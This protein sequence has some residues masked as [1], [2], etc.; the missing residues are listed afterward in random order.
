MIQSRYRLRKTWRGPQGEPPTGADRLSGALAVNAGRRPLQIYLPIADMP[1]NIFLVLGMGLAVGYISGMFGIGGGFLMTP[2]LIFIGVS[3]AVAVASVASHIAASSFSGAINYWN[4][5]ALDL[6]LA[7]ML[8]SA[9]IIG[10]ATGVWLFTTLRALDQL[11]LMIGLSYVTL[12]TIVGGLMIYESVRAVVRARHGLPAT[13]RRPG[14]HTWLHGLPFKLRF[15]RSKIYVS[16][17]PVWAIGFI[18]GFVGA[19]DACGHQPSG[20][21]GA[22]LDPDGRR[23]GRRAIRRA[24]RTE[25][26]GRTAAPPA[27]P[28]GFR[29]RPTLRLCVGGTAGRSVLDTPPRGRMMR[30]IALTLVIVMLA[31]GA[32]P[33]AAERLVVS[34]SNHRV[35][36]TSSFV[37]EDLVL[38]GTIEPDAG[39]TALR[40]AYDLVV[41]V[42]GPRQS[43]R[44]RRKQRVLGIWVNVDSR[45]FVRVPSYLA[46][47][48]NRPVAQITQQDTLRRLQ[49]GLDNCLLPQRIGPDL[50]DTV[51][52]DPFR[53]AFVRLEIQQALYSEIGSAVTFLTPTV[54]RTAIPL[55][56]D[57]PTGNYT[58]DVKLFADGVMVARTNSALEVTKAGFEQYVADA[59]RDHGLLYGLATMLM[60]LLTGGIA[61]VMFRRD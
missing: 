38:F 43:L 35:A 51:R 32:K 42:T 54:F 40:S 3:P 59:A 53:L 15:K 37:G 8:L 28:A 61:S 12:L 58:I 17:I 55:P 11:D 57:V 39:K 18:I 23:R 10:T 46:I 26:A 27:R 13:I 14:S 4:R 47:L 5:R 36:I 50:A 20:R 31:C 34:L 2:L 16:A 30:R 24:H 33:A 49:I 25:D 48:S 22:G 1:V 44:T 29:G 52:D 7:L 60:A 45:E 21:R 6:A 9:G 41:T 56:A 19:C